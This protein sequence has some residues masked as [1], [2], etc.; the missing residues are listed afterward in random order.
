MEFSRKDFKRNE[1]LE[2]LEEVI[3]WVKNNPQNALTVAGGLVLVI[4]LAIYFYVH[5]QNVQKFISDRVSYATNLY[6]YG[7]M[8]D[9]SLK[10]LDEI[11]RSYPHSPITSR[12]LLLRS[13]IY[14]E[15][16]NFAQALADSEEL[17]RRKKPKDIIPFGYIQMGIV[18]Q[19]MGNYLAAVS[20]YNE[21]L[22][23]YPDHFYVPYVYDALGTIYLG[24]NNTD[25]ARSVYEKI[26]TMY[27]GTFWSQKAQTLLSALSVSSTTVSS[28]H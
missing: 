4:A 12:A 21:F 16:K 18:Q 25:E 23:K 24:I 8:A 2:L 14:A 28:V 11:I 5:Y 10:I 19:R 6:Y 7:K 3:R 17:V 1:L 15:K 13:Q 27:P 9:E 20:S 26:V 22:N